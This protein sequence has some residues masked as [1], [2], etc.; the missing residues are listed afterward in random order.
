M[1]LALVTGASN[2]LGKELAVKLDQRGYDLVLAAR[3]KDALEQLAGTLRNAKVVACDLSTSEGVAQLVGNCDVPD[4]LV[5]NAGFGG[6]GPFAE[7]DPAMV[8]RMIAVNCGALTGLTQ[9]YLPQMLARNSG[10][11]L[12]IA[13]TASFQAGPNQAVYCASKAYVL[14]FTEAVAEEVRKSAVKVVA[15]C[16]G[17]FDSGFQEAAH[18]GNA[19]LFKGRKLKSSAEIADAA[20]GAMDGSHVVVVPGLSNKVGAQATRFVPRSLTRRVVAMVQAEA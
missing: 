9:A 5:N 17:A 8:Q 13:S 4:V 3:S 6:L 7:S 11:I 19:R 14:S 10:T 2:G 15:F 20:L 1:A 16:P 12:N 18:A